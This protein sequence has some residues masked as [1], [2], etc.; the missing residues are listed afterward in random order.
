[1]H[2]YPQVQA[3]FERRIEQ[4]VES[5]GRR[6]VGW[7]EI[8]AGGVSRSA[9]IMSWRGSKP[10]RQA[11]ELGNDAV[12]TPDGPLYLDAYQGD[13]NQ[14]P[15]AIGS[16]ST[17]RMV[18][19]YDP[20]EGISAPEQRAHILGVQGN[21]WTEWIGS[22]P[23]LFYM[24]LPRELALSEA[25][26]TARADKDWDSFAQ[27]MQPQYL[28]LQNAAYNFRIP[29]PS[30][31]LD[32]GALHFN[33][34][35]NVQAVSADTQSGDVTLSLSDGDPA[36]AI[37]YTTDGTQPGAHALRYTGAL[38]LTLAP[39]ERAHVMSAAML[40]DGRSSTVTELLLTRSK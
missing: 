7:D 10:G 14:E 4:F 19:D 35:P 12:M 39:G 34:A 23:Q 25:G 9:V 17:L 36:A 30:M 6:M 13:R 29:N 5:K 15:L 21:I 3:Y 22:V 33:I 31:T 1:L 24:A 16:L 2:T 40:P 28:Y 20:L 37:F 38:H 32:G 18:Y 8:L 27:R 26:W 11:A